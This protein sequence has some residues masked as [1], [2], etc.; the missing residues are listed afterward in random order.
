MRRLIHE[1]TAVEFP[2]P[3]PGSLIV[4]VLG[5]CPEN[6]AARHEQ[7]AETLLVECALERLHRLV[8]SVL[9]YNEEMHVRIIACLHELVGT[10]ERNRHRLLGDDVLPCFR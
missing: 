5:P 3:A 10:L 6:S 7:P 1:C 2:C 8:Q 4:I 9:L